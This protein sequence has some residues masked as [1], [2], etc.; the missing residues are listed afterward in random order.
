MSAGGRNP[1]I[2]DDGGELIVAS[3]ECPSS[4][5]N[6]CPDGATFYR[7][8]VA[9]GSATAIASIPHDPRALIDVMVSNDG[10]S[11]VYLRDI[12]RRIDVYDLDFTT[13]LTTVQP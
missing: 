10:R 12:E 6:A 7:V 5:D 3:P 2:R 4:S 9:T 13:L 11:L 8:D 1:W